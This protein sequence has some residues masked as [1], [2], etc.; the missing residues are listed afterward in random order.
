[1]HLFRFAP[2]SRRSGLRRLG[3]PL[4]LLSA[5]PLA[6][7]AGCGGGEPTPAVPE[8][9][10]ASASAA[11]PA[12]PAMPEPPAPAA[13]PP[14]P[15]TS[16]PDVS[17]GPGVPSDNPKKAP[18]VSILAPARDAS[19]APDK[20]KDAEVKL[21]VTGWDTQK[22]GPHVHLILDNHPYKRIDDP[23][24]PVKIG[25]LVGPNEAIAEGEHILVAFPSRMNHESVKMP[26]ALAVTRFWVGKK[27][28]STWKP[29]DPMLIY[30]RP[31][32][33]YNGSA[34]DHILVD[35]YL[36]HVEFPPKGQFRVKA[37]V[38]G[39]GLEEGGRT[40]IV[41][42]WRPYYLDYA[43]SGD[44]TVTLDL[45]NLAGDP[46]EGPWNHTTRTFTV[47]REAP[48]DAP[49]AGHGDHHGAGDHHGPNDKKDGAPKK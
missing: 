40:A 14:A 36:S 7:A 24:V 10:V 44:Y 11:P 38:Q 48:D 3:T 21:S 29:T 6:L 35:F 49:A 16:M 41:D 25:D 37:N 15:V 33:T 31:K 13:P 1:M 4:S 34:A 30:S 8:A 22:D 18:R 32:G 42:Q 20:V 23:K 43:R 47:N 46:V 45:V 19:I 28:T 17:F 39:P 27:G 12:P 26:G 5:L 2:L 9:P